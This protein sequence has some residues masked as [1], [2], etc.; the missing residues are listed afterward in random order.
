MNDKAYAQT[1]DYIPTTDA[2]F[3]AWLTVFS[4]KISQDPGK[5]GLNE[6]D[7]QIIASLQ[8]QFNGLFIKCQDNETRS[9]G[10]IIQKDAVRASAK[11]TCRVYAQQI[12]AN[13]GVDSQ[14][15]LQLGVH[16]NDP[17]KTPIPAPDSAPMLTIQAA[18]SGEHIIRYVDE[19]TPTKRA[20][21]ANVTQLELFV[22]VGP[23]PIVNWQDAKSVGV[24]TKNPIKYSF[25]PEKAGQ[26][27]T[28]FARWRTA[29]G[30]DGPMSLPVAM[31]IAFGGPVDQQ[32]EQFTPDGGQPKQLGGGEDDLKIAA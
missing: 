5:Y 30:L 3:N 2:G 22:H 27:A 7:A 8:Q 29:R 10:L 25:S 15:K 32:L 6:Q 12:K 31:L 18:F 26:C 24:F 14:A 9:P 1:G 17:T 20:K 23:T 28:Y 4:S 11:G 19:N 16:V 21:P 13:Q